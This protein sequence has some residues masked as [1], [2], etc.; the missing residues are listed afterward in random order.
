MRLTEFGHACVRIEHAEGAVLIDPGMFGAPEVVAGVSA[1]LITREHA[2]HL[3]D[4]RPRE[5]VAI[6]EATLSEAGQ[7]IHG[8]LPG[9][10]GPGTGGVEHRTLGAGE[11]LG[12]A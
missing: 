8:R 10:Q 3:R 4:A 12:L 1:L 9:P 6:H 7:A 11:S 5:A 2:D